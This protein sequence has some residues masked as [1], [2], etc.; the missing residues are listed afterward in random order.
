M[1]HR[2]NQPEEVRQRGQRN[3]TIR[4]REVRGEKKRQRIQ[5]V[6]KMHAGGL[7]PKVIAQRLCVNVKT[8]YRALETLRERGEINDD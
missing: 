5:Q 4:S 1:P 2:Y 3:A 8:V 6:Q 7:K